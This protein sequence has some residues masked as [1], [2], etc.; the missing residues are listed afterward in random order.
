MSR[1]LATLLSPRAILA[2]LQRRIEDLADEE[3]LWEP[4]P[5]CMSL[6][7]GR[8]DD[9]PREPHHFDGGEPDPVTTIGWRLAHIAIDGLLAARNAE[10]LGVDSTPPATDVPRTADDARRVLDAGIEWWCGLVEGCEDDH[11]RTPIGPVGGAFGD[12]PR[13]AF[14][15]HISNDV[16]HHG[17]EVG[18]LRDLWRAGLR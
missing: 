17:G 6:R 16:I 15:V 11:L 8:M 10:W 14:I 5:G 2:V 4:V 7:D 9:L 18:V 13:A 1:E 12:V 3:M